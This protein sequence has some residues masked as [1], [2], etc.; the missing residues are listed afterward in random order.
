MI[1]WDDMR[2]ASKEKILAFDQV[3]LREPSYDA[4]D[5]IELETSLVR[6]FH[7]PRFVADL[8]D[9]AFKV[10]SPKMQTIHASYL[11]NRHNVLLFGSSN[12]VS[13]DGYWSCENRS[14]RSIHLQYMQYS[15]FPKIFPGESPKIEDIGTSPKVVTAELA[16]T[17]SVR[18]IDEPVFLATPIEPPIWGR[19]VAN[20]MPRVRHYRK[21]GQGRKFMCHANRTW[22]RYTLNAL[23]I[24]DDE[25]IHHDPGC[26]YICRDVMLQEYEGPILSMSLAERAMMND[27]VTH[28]RVDTKFGKKLFVS[29]LTA[30]R[31]NPDYRTLL[32]EVEVCDFFTAKGFSVIEPELLPLPDQISAFRNADVVVVIGGSAMFNTAFSLPGTRVV[33]IESSNNYIASHIE[34]LSALDMEY[35]VIFGQQ[36]PNDPR[37]NHGRWT[38]DAQRAYDAIVAAWPDAA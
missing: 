1:A 10:S 27:I 31:N 7:P 13:Q 19:W 30:S 18:W 2:V 33:T 34:Y 21:H 38:V 4:I 9:K 16:E 29:R 24:S 37:A 25:I 35:G 23:G 11:V 6:R 22:E 17:Q 36:D 20:V 32:N 5:Q 8:S 14:N 26:T 3:L 15:F 28:N 12:L